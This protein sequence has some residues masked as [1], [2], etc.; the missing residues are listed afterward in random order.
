M[1][2]YDVTGEDGS[3]PAAAKPGGDGGSLM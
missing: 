2:I 3:S 1:S